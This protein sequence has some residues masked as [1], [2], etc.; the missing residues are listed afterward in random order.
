MEVGPTVPA[1]LQAELKNDWAMRLAT[2]PLGGSQVIH[3]NGEVM[4]RL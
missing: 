3:M 2:E 1:D 4:I